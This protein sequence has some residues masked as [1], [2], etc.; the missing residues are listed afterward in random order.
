M[1]PCSCVLTPV[2]LLDPSQSVQTQLTHVGTD[3]ELTV[4]LQSHR[5]RGSNYWLCCRETLN[6][7]NV[8]H[9]WVWDSVCASLTLTLCWI[10]VMNAVKVDS[11]DV[12]LTT[13]NARL[14][15]NLLPATIKDSRCAKLVLSWFV[16]EEAACG[17]LSLRTLVEQRFLNSNQTMAAVCSPPGWKLLV[18]CRM[19][20]RITEELREE[21]QVWG[22][23]RT[24]WS[25]WYHVSVLCLSCATNVTLKMKDVVRHWRNVQETWGTV[26]N[27]ASSQSEPQ[28]GPGPHLSAHLSQASWWQR[29][30]QT[31]LLLLL[32]R[33]HP[34]ISTWCF[35]WGNFCCLCSVAES[36]AWL[37]DLGFSLHQ[38][39]DGT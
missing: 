13:H 17:F 31:S 39:A 12:R 36:G 28:S 26:C 25:N 33:Y 27:K 19:S 37:N 18:L 10:S 22:A 1:Q 2:R 30:K 11:M 4:R 24:N 29:L 21:S 6:I 20:W 35:L 8:L 16:M 32:C 14:C 34:I 23:G 7:P 9:L 15:Q 3:R 38:H 5:T